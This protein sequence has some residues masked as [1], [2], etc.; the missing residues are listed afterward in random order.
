MLAHREEKKFQQRE[1][2]AFVGSSEMLR[3]L[4]PSWT[5]IEPLVCADK[6][7][8]TDLEDSNDTVKEKM[9]L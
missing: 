8:S 2:N 9:R 3:C 5:L 1:P 7:T 6:G 4:I